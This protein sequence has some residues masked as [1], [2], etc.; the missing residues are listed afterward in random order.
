MNLGYNGEIDQITP[1]KELN[2]WTKLQ[3]NYKCTTT[4]ESISNANELEV[5]IAAKSSVS[6]NRLYENIIGENYKVML[7]DQIEYQMKYSSISKLMSKITRTKSKLYQVTRMSR[8]PNKSEL[9]FI[10]K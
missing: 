8:N 6:M 10:C 9:T 5:K 1:S 7:H 4:P 2:Q 3:L